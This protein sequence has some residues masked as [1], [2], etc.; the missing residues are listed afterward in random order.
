MFIGTEI[1]TLETKNHLIIPNIFIVDGLSDIVLTS[2][3]DKNLLLVPEVTFSSLQNSIKNL[4]LLDP[5]V[6]LLNRMVVGRASLISL[7]HGQS[8]TLPQYLVDFAELTTRIVMVGQ[9]AFVELWSENNWKKQSL[10]LDSG[11]IIFDKNI[12]LTL[13]R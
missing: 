1:T 10:L 3:F 9:G 13:E 12:S 6:R 2:G 7:E 5:A 4:N 8:I 11:E